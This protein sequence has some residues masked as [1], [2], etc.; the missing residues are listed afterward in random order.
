MR[1]CILLSIMKGAYH[2]N[3][4]NPEYEVLELQLPVPKAPGRLRG[5]TTCA[6]SSLLSSTLLHA[7]CATAAPGAC[8]RMT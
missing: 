1:L 2:T 4:S 8:S 5:C 7:S 6:G 3:L